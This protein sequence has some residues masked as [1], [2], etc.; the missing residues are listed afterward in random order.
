MPDNPLSSLICM[1]QSLEHPVK[2][3]C[4][5]VHTLVTERFSTDLRKNLSMRELFR[6]GISCIKTLFQLVNSLTLA[7]GHTNAFISRIFVE[8]GM[9]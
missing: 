7:T 4:G 9:L 2:T 8:I 5:H 6:D 1:P 3:W